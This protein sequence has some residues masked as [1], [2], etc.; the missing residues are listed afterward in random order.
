MHSSTRQYYYNHYCNTFTN[1]RTEKC[2][3]CKSYNQMNAPFKSRLFLW[4]YYRMFSKLKL[5][6]YVRATRLA[7]NPRLTCWDSPL[8][9]FSAIECICVCVQTERYSSPRLAKFF[10]FLFTLF[11]LLFTYNLFCFSHS[12]LLRFG[13]RKKNFF[14]FFRFL[15]G[16]LPVSYAY[17]NVTR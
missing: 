2:L 14:L 13:I 8:P 9:S 11:Q 6:E 5:R 15:A 1:F 4:R 17:A 12:S 7:F 10:F 3:L 16:K